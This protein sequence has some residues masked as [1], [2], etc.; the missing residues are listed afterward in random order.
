[1]DKN[2]PNWV[3]WKYEKR[4]GKMTKILTD[5]R[6]NSASSTDP[7]TWTTYENVKGKSQIGFVLPLDKKTL[8]IDLD[9]CIDDTGEVVYEHFRKL[10]EQSNTYMEYSPS[11]KGLHLFFKLTEPLDLKAK[12]SKKCPGFEC[13]TFGRY[14]TV[15]ELPYGEKKE[16]RII[17]P[18]EAEEILSIVGY[19]WKTE[20]QI[21]PT[22]SS[23]TVLSLTN[24]EIK[25]RMFASKKNGEKIKKLWNGNIS[26]YDNDYSSADM[27]LCMHLAFWTQRNKERIRELW[28]SAPLGARKKTQERNDYQE[29]TINKAI[30]ETNEIYTP[31]EGVQMAKRFDLMTTDKGDP[32]VNEENL[33]R[34]MHHDDLIFESFRF[35]EFTNEVE[36]NLGCDEWRQIQ[37][38]DVI[39]VMLHFQK[40][41]PYFEKV[42]KQ[43]VDDALTIFSFTNKINPPKK[44]IESMEWDGEHRLNRWLT[45][46][47]GV[48]DT[49]YYASVGANWMKGLVKR[50]VK[51]GCKFDFMIILEGPQGWMKSTSLSVLGKG[52][53]VETIITPEN[54][55]FLM[56]L[57]RNS[58]VEFSEGHTMNRSDTRLLKSIITMTEDQFRVPYGRGITRYPRHC[59]FAMTTNQESYLRDETG[60]RRFLPIEV[61]KPA[62][63]EWLETNVDQLY[64]EA[65]HRVIVLNETIYE[66]PEEETKTMQMS[67]MIENPYEDKLLNWY[68]NIP[69]YERMNGITALEA[70]QS[71]WQDSVSMGRE[72]TIVQTMQVTSLFATALK[73]RKKQT[74]L[75]GKRAMRWYPSE[76]TKQLLSQI[77]TEKLYDSVI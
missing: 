64:A 29:R 36:T 59:V 50:I 71:V 75:D 72:M 6:G 30:S 61:Q 77:T 67:K 25:N 33:R 31:S 69:E 35:N 53:H 44:W 3:L 23:Q 60:N 8:A 55:D 40:N 47:Y 22:A 4:A 42:R 68:K 10:I 73:L 57:V 43:A 9:K 70:Y 21:Q 66:F 27:A 45:D 32:I 62:D 17:T 12:R 20:L 63:L 15:T 65:Y 54:K 24:E 52:Y 58:I 11:K 76:E 16:I 51:P 56:L 5:L 41:Y 37:P 48:S 7:A 46:V 2:I 38:Y 14:M 74:T 1:M 39:F 18:Q 49:S 26:E 34:M 28:L 13:Y 19:P